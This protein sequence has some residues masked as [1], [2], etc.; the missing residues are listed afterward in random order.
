MPATRENRHGNSCMSAMHS[1]YR[2]GALAF[3]NSRW[4]APDAHTVALHALVCLLSAAEVDEF[5]AAD[6][7]VGHNN[8][9]N[10]RYEGSDAEGAR[11]VLAE[12]PV[13]LLV[14]QACEMFR[15]RHEV[16]TACCMLMTLGARFSSP[17]ESCETL[18]A[19]E[20]SVSK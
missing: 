5:D 15:G 16:V 12:E 14:L 2:T 3:N 13:L 17:A 20:V 4:V 7:G 19:R 8:T 1:T 6:V 11:L 9:I 10:A 18:K